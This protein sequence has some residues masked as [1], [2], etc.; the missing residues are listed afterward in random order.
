MPAM[1]QESQE[2]GRFVNWYEEA[3]PLVGVITRTRSL[4]QIKEYW[5]KVH[6]RQHMKRTNCAIDNQYD[7]WT[8]LLVC[9]SRNIRHRYELGL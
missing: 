4:A 7:T 6:I 8:R 2:N 3:L 1:L 5:V 9:G